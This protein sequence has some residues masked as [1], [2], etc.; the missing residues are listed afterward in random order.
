MTST[1]CWHCHKLAQMVQPDE[2]V[3]DAYTAALYN[4]IPS[5]P[6]YRFANTEDG[7]GPFRRLLIYSCVSCG[8]PNIAELCIS[9]DDARQGYAPDEH[10]QR[11]LPVEPVGKEYP[12]APGEVASVASEVHKCLEIGANRAAVTLARTAL[13][14]IVSDLEDAPSNEK[15]YQRLNHLAGRGV[16]K[17]RTAEAATAVRLCGNASTH[18]A[19]CEIDE[20]FAEIVVEVLDSVIDDLYTHPALVDKAKAYAERAKHH[21]RR[22][23]H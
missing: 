5:F 4:H 10:I 21:S 1:T 22:Q 16:L 14:G 18:E 15:L 9:E 13:E 8:Y 2:P 7:D 3:N 17:P 11:W 12:D 20:E 23:L 6:D 19:D